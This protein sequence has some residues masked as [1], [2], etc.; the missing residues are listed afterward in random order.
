MSM[1]EATTATSMQVRTY[2][3]RVQQ[4]VTFDVFYTI[5]KTIFLGD[6][7]VANKK[8]IGG[9][10]LIKNLNEKSTEFVRQFCGLLELL[11]CEKCD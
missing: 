5:F 6:R 4:V 7:I 3:D 2:S 1:S 8:R 10:K 9:E 11:K